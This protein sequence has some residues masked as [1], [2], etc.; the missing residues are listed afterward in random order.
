MI[1]PFQTD[2]SVARELTAA[3][4][5]DTLQQCDDESGNLDPAKVAV[6]FDDIEQQRQRDEK[7]MEELHR[8]EATA[9]YTSADRS[10]HFDAIIKKTTPKGFRGWLRADVEWRYTQGT[11]FHEAYKT[12]ALIGSRNSFMKWAR[13]DSDEKTQYKILSRFCFYPMLIAES[14]RMVFVR[15]TKGQITYMRDGPENRAPKFIGKTLFKVN[16]H[17]PKENTQLRNIIITLERVPGGEVCGLEFLFD[18]EQF[19]LVNFISI[20]AFYDKGFEALVRAE[21]IDRPKALDDFL[22][23]CFEPFRCGKLDIYY[24]NLED[25]LVKRRYKVGL[26]EAVGTNFLLI[27]ESVGLP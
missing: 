25:Y 4:F 3:L 10:A 13:A 17:L 5:A 9:E 22:R 6:L 7:R 2:A 8:W 12:L 11:H 18:G 26:S 14:M 27:Q 21:L 19:H 15:A 20:G 23:H 16:V 24:K 1:K